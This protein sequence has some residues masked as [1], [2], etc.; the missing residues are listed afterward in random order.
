MAERVMGDTYE[1]LMRARVFDALGMTWAGFRVSGSADVVDEPRGHFGVLGWSVAV[2]PGPKA[3]NPLFT[4]PSGG[5][6]C[7]L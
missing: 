1:E 4:A 2:P 6:H 3:D 5:I 7:S